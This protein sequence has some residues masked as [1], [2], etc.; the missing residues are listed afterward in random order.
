ME[1]NESKT[2]AHQ[3]KLFHNNRWEFS[4]KASKGT[5][6]NE[7][8][9]TSFSKQE[10]DIF[11]PNTYSVPKLIDYQ[12]IQWFPFIKVKPEDPSFTPFNMDPIRPKDVK[13]ILKQSNQKSSPGPDGVPYGILS[14]LPCT[15]HILSTLFNKVMSNGCPPNSW[16]ESMI[17]LIHK[18][19]DSK[20]PRNF[21]MI[22]LTSTIGKTYHLLLSKRTTKSA[23]F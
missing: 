8:I 16:S 20:D 22:A 12:N 17:K 13:N 14:K 5:P 19:G 18:K 6:G 1:H 9:Q 21:R 3:E 4:R 2:A 11:Y 23:L 15:H 7:N 10:A